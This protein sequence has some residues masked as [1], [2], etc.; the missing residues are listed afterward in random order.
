MVFMNWLW[1]G[2]FLVLWQ[3]SC[4]HWKGNWGT[5]WY[6]IKSE[7]VHERLFGDLVAQSCTM[8]FDQ[9]SYK[10]WIMKIQNFSNLKTRGFSEKARISAFRRKKCLLNLVNGSGSYEP[11]H[12]STLMIFIFVS[13]KK[14]NGH[15]FQ[16]S[17][18]WTQFFQH[19]YYILH[20][21]LEKA[22]PIPHFLIIWRSKIWDFL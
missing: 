19:F 7:W 15:D 18:L 16:H 1:E 5:F 20:Q 9:K 22:Q 17:R 4:I 14:R 11:K 12:R 21:N 3:T 8:F 6:F 10:S 13:K 2:Q